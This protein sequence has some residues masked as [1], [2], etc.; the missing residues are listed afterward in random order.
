M[1]FPSSGENSIPSAMFRKIA[2]G[3]A[4]KLCFKRCT[5]QSWIYYSPRIG[6][7]L[8]IQSRALIL[9]ESGGT[10]LDARLPEK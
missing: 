2:M 7:L 1:G 5:R 4:L 3:Q 8:S 6:K 9:G 10:Q